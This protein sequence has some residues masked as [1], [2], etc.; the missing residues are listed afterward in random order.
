FLIH[1]LQ[2]DG[3]GRGGQAPQTEKLKHWKY[4]KSK[5]REVKL[6]S[7]IVD[8]VTD[9]GNRAAKAPVKLTSGKSQG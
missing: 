8:A 9:L 5:S 1:S 7:G 4:R 2:P 6:T 3:G